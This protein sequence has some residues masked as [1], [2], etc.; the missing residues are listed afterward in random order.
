[1]QSLYAAQDGEQPG[2]E[3]Q[4]HLEHQ[5]YTQF[6][7]TCGA[8]LP[9]AAGVLCPNGIMHRM[10]LVAATGIAAC[11]LKYSFGCTSEYIQESYCLSRSNLSR[12]S[13]WSC[14]GWSWCLS[15]LI[16][17][18]STWQDGCDDRSHNR[19]VNDD[20]NHA[21]LPQLVDVDEALNGYDGDEVEQCE[22][23]K[24]AP[25]PHKAHCPLPCAPP[26]KQVSGAQ[27]AC[28]FYSSGDRLL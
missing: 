8:L 27:D 9:M 4:E 19:Q 25:H 2:Q 14:R 24:S 5:A 17:Q 7:V 18:N 26:G 15:A 6:R 23:D 12:S 1:M 3:C 16:S 10:V 28:G 20:G 13:G 21:D 11:C 22:H